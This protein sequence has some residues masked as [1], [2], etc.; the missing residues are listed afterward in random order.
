MKMKYKK[1]IDHLN[2]Q[3]E[4]LNRLKPIVKYQQEALVGNSLEGLDEAVK[5]EDILLSKIKGEQMMLKEIL[6][7]INCDENLGMKEIR[8]TEFISLKAKEE[9]AELKTLSTLKNRIENLVKEIIGINLQNNF[10]INHARFLIK[11]I[12]SAAAASPNN[13]LLDRRM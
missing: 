2:N 12:I 13:V 10:L 9:S 11:E 4:T 3:I 8:L 5:Q 7:K 6:Q 1:I